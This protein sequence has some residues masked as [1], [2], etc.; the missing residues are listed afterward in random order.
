ME[1]GHPPPWS[2]GGNAASR[3]AVGLGEF[4]S[5]RCWR[6]DCPTAFP[7]LSCW[8]PFPLAGVGDGKCPPRPGWTAKGAPKRTVTSFSRCAR[9]Q[10]LGYVRG[11]T[12]LA[13][14]AP[15]GRDCESFPSPHLPG[16]GFAVRH[17]PLSFLATVFAF[18]HLGASLVFF[19]TTAWTC[20]AIF[21]SFGMFSYR[22]EVDLVFGV[23]ILRV[24]RTSLKALCLPLDE[25]APLRS[26]ATQGWGWGWRRSARFTGT[27]Q[28]NVVQPRP[29]GQQKAA[30][31]PANR[32]FYFSNTQIS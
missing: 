22:F 13:P 24:L 23:R 30:S 9:A 8:A 5:G 18:K 14:P 2:G 21:L 1:T 12:F 10:G 4:L 6:P 19:F 27:G 26:E 29:G 16:T 25:M 7:A 3:V 32:T 28:E 15:P 11:G 17:F 31:S 20:V